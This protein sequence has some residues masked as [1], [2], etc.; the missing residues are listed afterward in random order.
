MKKIVLTLMLVMAGTLLK[1]QILTPVTWA[2]AAK[3][4]SKTQAMVMIRATVDEGWHIYSQN[5]ADG[6]P[7]KTTFTFSADKKYQLAG[8][9]IEPKPITRY[10]KAFGMNVS[11]FEHSVVFQQKVKLNGAGPVVVKGSLEYMTCNDEKRLPPDNLE[12]T[13]TIK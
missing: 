8:K 9:T 10:E 12:F 13:V 6:G 2:Y 11:Y 5:V 7:V 1:A 4:I 3:R